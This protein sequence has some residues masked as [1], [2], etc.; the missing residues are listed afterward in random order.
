MR[1][2]EPITQYYRLSFDSLA[3]R[4][5]AL[6]VLRGP[7][8]V[9]WR[10]RHAADPKRAVFLGFD[11]RVE[12]TP[13]MYASEGGVALTEEFRFMCLPSAKPVPVSALPPGL[14]VLWGGESIDPYNLPE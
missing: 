4:E 13:V 2:P 10:I 1:M 14:T 6:D 9:E 7:V 8:G 5:I 3:D 11:A 12:P